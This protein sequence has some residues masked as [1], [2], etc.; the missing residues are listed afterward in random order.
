MAQNNLENTAPSPA[1]VRGPPEWPY[2]KMRGTEGGFR[3]VYIILIDSDKG[4]ALEK[5]ETDDERLAY[6]RENADD[7]WR[8][9]QADTAFFE[10]ITLGKK[11]S[12]KKG[13]PEY[14]GLQKTLQEDG[15]SWPPGTEEFN[16][17]LQYYREYATEVEDI[18]TNTHPH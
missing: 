17:M 2:Y 3:K 11:Y 7:S 1:L 16:A 18:A 13:T 12:I 5:L 8:L 14:E 9:V 10:D 6:M 4:R 15:S